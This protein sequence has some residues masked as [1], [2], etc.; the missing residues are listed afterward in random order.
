MVSKEK[1]LRFCFY[2]GS[3][4]PDINDIK[5]I[6]CPYCGVK[7]PYKIKNQRSKNNS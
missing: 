1:E 2:C 4:L 3:L 7:L 5:N 6:H